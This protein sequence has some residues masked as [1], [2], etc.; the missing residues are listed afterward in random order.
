M[1]F[2]SDIVGGITGSTAADAASRG[3]RELSEAAMRAGDM[4]ARG[5]RQAFDFFREQLDPFAGAFGKKDIRGLNALA[6]DPEAQMNFLQNNPLFESLMN[7][8]KQNTFR[9]QSAGGMLGSSGTEEMMQNAFL[10][11][12]NELINQQINRQMPL[13]QSAQN[14]STNLG[15]YGGNTLI[16][17]KDALARALE[18]SAQARASGRIG[19]ANANAEG[20]SNILGA[21]G[22]ALSFLSD[23][24]LKTDI[25]KTGKHGQLN[26]YKWK[27][28]KQAE[29][30]GL[31]GEAQGH[32]AQ[33]VAA[34]Y[35]ELIGEHLGFMTINYGTDKT[36][37]YGH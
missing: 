25:R 3:G 1:G 5:G 27:W 17:I 23:A 11:R 6:T 35:P 4:R 31:T 10:T 30:L 13:F 19:A 7:Q 29:S 28:N 8:A 34:I 15:Q 9:T 18:D 24:Q 14:A 12:G 22:S 32:I 2:L 20:T 21:A 37:N 36:V 26:V 16:G 33:E